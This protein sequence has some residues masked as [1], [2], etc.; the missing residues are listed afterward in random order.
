[1]C[2]IVSCAVTTRRPPHLPYFIMNYTIGTLVYICRG[3]GRTPCAP[4]ITSLLRA[5]CMS[6]CQIT[7]I[8]RS[9]LSKDP[10]RRVDLQT[11]Q[12]LLAQQ[13]LWDMQGHDNALPLPNKVMH[14]LR[15]VVHNSR[16][17]LDGLGWWE[18]GNVGADL[19]GTPRG[20]RIKQ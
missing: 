6:T 2:R 1:M 19:V 11:F 18:D 20:K 9:A 5:L 8:A 13:N 17:V 16:R 3:N 14:A 12:K 15:H 10:R 4:S 7:I